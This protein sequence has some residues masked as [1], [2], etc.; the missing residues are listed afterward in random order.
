MLHLDDEKVQLD[1]MEVFFHEYSYPIDLVSVSDPIEALKLID[2]EYFDSL[3]T[4][5]KMPEI[6][7]GLP[8]G[9]RGPGPHG[10]EVGHLPDSERVRREDGAK[11]L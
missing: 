8:D 6:N 10:A 4:D 3:V 5:I 9:C 7:G 1:M 11:G 2:E